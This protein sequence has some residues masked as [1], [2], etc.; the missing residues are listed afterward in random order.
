M[1]LRNARFGAPLTVIVSATFT[2]LFWGCN[3]GDVVLAENYDAAPPS[4]LSPDATSVAPEAGLIEYC[5]SDKCP[6]GRTTCAGSRFPCDVDLQTD[7]NNCGGCGLACPQFTNDP[8]TCVE[9]VCVMRCSSDTADCDGILENGCEKY[10]GLPDNDNCG[11]CGNQCSDPSKPCIMRD[12][13]G[14]DLGCGCHAG[15]RLCPPNPEY[16]FLATCNGPDE[17]SN[18]GA[19]DN[20]CPRDG[21]GSPVRAN[22]Y[23]GC[24]AGQCGH[25]KCNPGFLD[26]DGD[27]TNG[28]EVDGTTTENCGACGNKGTPGQVCAADP[29]GHLQLMC[30][31]GFTFCGSC[32]NGHCQGECFD[33]RSDDKNCGGCGHRCSGRDD[34]LDVRGTSLGKCSYGVCKRECIRGRA[35]CNGDP[36]D[37]CE[38]NTDD[39][40][41]NCGGC[42]RACNAIAGQACIGGRCVMEPCDRDAGGTVQ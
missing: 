28:C 8:M 25:F 1:F 12:Q 17:D 26:C 19:C 14:L 2:W 7:L 6:P 24:L 11:G 16:W 38:V 34:D 31:P 5:P 22:G 4:L 40:P 36:S 42:G 33:L 15:E 27:L 9:G 39:D 13:F 32:P 3:G 20:A 37:D 10:L 23:Y 41:R 30:E 18:C 21:D 35:D 29:K